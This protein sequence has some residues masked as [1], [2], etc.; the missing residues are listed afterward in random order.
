MTVTVANTANTNVVSYFRTR[1][2]ELAYA[3]TT[4]A[5]TVNSN[6]AVGNAT[7]NGTVT[8]WTIAANTIGG[9]TAAAAGNLS[10]TTNVS[11]SGKVNLGLGANVV[12]TVGN[13]S[14]RV[15]V[16]NNTDN[17]LYAT[18][19][20]IASDMS[21]V[22]LSSIANNQVMV[23]SA[24]SAAF[25]NQN[26]SGLTVNN[27]SYLDGQAQTFY[28]N[29]SNMSSGKLPAGRL[30][31]GDYTVNS[32]TTVANVTASSATVLNDFTVKNATMTANA[33]ITG[34]SAATVLQINTATDTIRG[35]EM[36]TSSLKRWR[37]AASSQ[38]ETGNNNGSNFTI[39]RYDDTGSQID[40]VLNIN[41]NSGLVSL[42]AALDVGAALSVTGNATLVN[43]AA[44]YANVTTLYSSNAA[45]DSIVIGGSKYSLR[46][47]DGT[48]ITP[49]VQMSGTSAAG[50]SEGLTSWSTVSGTGP[51]VLFNRAK[52]GSVGTHS[53]VSSS[54]TLG[55]IAWSGS[56][57]NSFVLGSYVMAEVDGTPNTNAMPT[58][59]RMY[60]SN[61]SGTTTE[62]LRLDAEQYVRV[63]GSGVTF[64]V[65][66][67]TAT[68][69][70]VDLTSTFTVQDSATVAN[71]LTV[72][73]PPGNLTGEWKRFLTRSGVTTLTVTSNTTIRGFT[74]GTLAAGTSIQAVYVSGFWFVTT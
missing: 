30:T 44:S 38:S 13:A 71:T 5:V 1:V 27:A 6:G 60:T 11:F 17:S 63:L 23:W 56:D 12:V 34:A 62:V 53:A 20:A 24:G 4:M 57:G 70:T 65:T 18:K 59:M 74:S 61:S 50:T 15:L 21:D 52:G 49:Q 31:T 36:L 14:H 66:R 3:M 55:A 22:A 8:A 9:G 28:T 26:V 72:N 35:V 7:V 51:Q 40:N 47:H 45:L 19:L 46:S 43:A 64:P 48:L 25:V 2:N 10:F 67:S 73:L 33:L 16:S 69:G 32:L 41:R 29:A 58:R 42:T 68:S 39:T 37:V 54:D